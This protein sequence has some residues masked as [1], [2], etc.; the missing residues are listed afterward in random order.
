M[1]KYAR[2]PTDRLLQLS[3]TQVQIWN[4]LAEGPKEAAEITRRTMG[5]G[6]FEIM[7]ALLDMKEHGDVVA[8][9]ED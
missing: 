1:I 8:I 5:A 6:Y 2:Q 9:Q 7:N 3:E 4:L